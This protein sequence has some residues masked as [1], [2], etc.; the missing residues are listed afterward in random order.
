MSVRGG[1]EASL[2][3]SGPPRGADAGAGGGVDRRGG[4]RG[5]V[6][7]ARFALSQLGYTPRKHTVYCFFVVIHAR[8]A[9]DKL[10]AERFQA[11]RRRKLVS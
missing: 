5:G 8:R 6:R 1:G 11:V 9:L 2:G 10:L 7:G 4:V 3:G